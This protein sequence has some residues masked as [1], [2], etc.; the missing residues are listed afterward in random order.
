MTRFVAKQIN[1]AKSQTDRRLLCNVTFSLFFTLS[2][3]KFFENTLKSSIFLYLSFINYKL[4]TNRTTSINWQNISESQ[5][6]IVHEASVVETNF[7]SKIDFQ[8]FLLPNFYTFKP[9]LT[10]F[11][12][13]RWKLFQ[14]I[15]ENKWIDNPNSKVC[16]NH[17]SLAIDIGGWLKYAFCSSTVVRIPC[18]NF[19]PQANLSLQSPKFTMNSIFARNLLT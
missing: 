14:I 10:K 16:H 9:L 18:P 13:I 2:D 5:T 8:L 3:K 15:I 4:L 19:K 12:Y 17:W 11:R 6:G 1:H 7:V